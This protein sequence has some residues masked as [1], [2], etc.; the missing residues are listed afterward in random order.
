MKL[1]TLNTHSLLEENYPEKLEQFVAVILKERPDIVAM[2][3][4]NQSIYAP[5]ADPT[6]LAGLCPVMENTIPV[7]RG[8]HA[9][10]V[11]AGLRRAGLPCS[12]SWLPIKIGYDAY[13]EGVALFSFQR[14]IAQ[15]DTCRISRSDDFQNWRT[16]K[17]LGIRVDGCSHWFY[18]VHMSWWQDKE[19]PFLYQWKTLEAHLAEKKETGT[20]WLLGDFNG[21]A[22]VRGE[23]YDCVKN[24]GWQDTY[25]LAARQ[26]SGVTVAGIIDGWR[27]KVADPDGMEG[28]RIDH[29]WCSR[30][31][32]VLRSQVIF[33]GKN[34]PV[35]SDHFGV[36]IETKEIAKGG[37][38]R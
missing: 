26:D 36:L 18:T 34:G 11:A 30:P 32:P 37:T 24:A 10:V 35:V 9:A 7:R 23:S 29:I 6:E 4:V 8:N 3:E 15:V 19:E 27:D 5:L 28:M 1:L 2:Q 14:P 16:R 20:V 13:E 38:V 25:T 22:E 12:W 33:N 17:V 21:P 31:Q